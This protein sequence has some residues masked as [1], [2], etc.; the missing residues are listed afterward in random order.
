MCSLYDGH[1]EPSSLFNPHPHQR[2]IADGAVV[3][4]DTREHSLGH[5]STARSGPQS[6]EGG[7]GETSVRIFLREV[8]LS[9]VYI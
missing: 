1:H 4:E 3:C 7:G 9:D 6:Q 2:L 8:P 5:W